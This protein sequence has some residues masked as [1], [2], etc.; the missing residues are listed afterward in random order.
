MGYPPLF[1]GDLQ[2]ITPLV[3]AHHAL[4]QGTRFDDFESWVTH[5]FEDDLEEIFTGYK[6]LIQALFRSFHEELDTIKKRVGITPSLEYKYAKSARADIDSLNT[7][8][9]ASNL[10][11]H[12][13]EFDRQIYR[14]HN[15]EYL[16]DNLSSLRSEV[17]APYRELFQKYGRTKTSLP[18]ED[19]LNYWGL[20]TAH[21]AV[22]DA[23]HDIPQAFFRSWF[24]RRYTPEEFDENF[25]GY[26]VALYWLY[27]KLA[28]EETELTTV[29]EVLLNAED[30]SELDRT[31]KQLSEALIKPIEDSEDF[32]SAPYEIDAPDS[33]DEIEHLL[34]GAPDPA[35]GIDKT[36][37]RTFL[38]KDAYRA[39]DVLVGSGSAG[40]VLVLKGLLGIRNEIESDDQIRIRRLKHPVDPGYDYSYA[41]EYTDWVSENSG[42]LHGWA[43]FL[44]IATD[45]SG[46]GGNQ[47]E[48]IEGLLNE[49]SN[50]DKIKI[51]ETEVPE[52]VLNRYLE[53][54]QPSQRRSNQLDEPKFDNRSLDRIIADGEGTRTEFKE[55]FPDSTIKVGK[56]IVALANYK[57][58]V[59]IYGVD[60][61]G[62]VK[63]IENQ[64]EVENKISAIL[65]D[66]IDPPLSAD[67]YTVSYEEEPIVI[68]DIPE[69]ERPVSCNYIYYYRNGENVRK[70]LYPE[71]KRRFG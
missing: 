10:T 15:P 3:G 46:F 7:E 41:I 45:Y 43:V 33:P 44:H 9:D 29:E 40:F 27:S 4:D 55:K 11:K 65:W 59:L 63:G 38:W 24:D 14:A 62:K 19:Y 12:L 49:L 71:L 51:K 31:Y 69:V 67:L 64:E 57:G 61:N 30:W 20:K 21:R 22:N 23:T 50:Q 13:N 34:E 66:T 56:E 53:E 37:N 5:N 8:C 25:E 35:V 36:L 6:I 52:D 28:S 60:D 54:Q 1:E 26:K 17:I 2:E 32:S 58:G 70:L 18:L 42:S 39:N 68:V 48:F 47:H 16:E